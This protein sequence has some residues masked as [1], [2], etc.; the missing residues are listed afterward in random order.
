MK[1]GDTPRRKFA[2]LLAALAAL[3]CGTAV[4]VDFTVVNDFSYMAMK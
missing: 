4:A 2:L 3:T 1:R